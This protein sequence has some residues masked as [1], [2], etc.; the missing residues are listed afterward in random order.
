[1]TQHQE[2]DSRPD[3]V[4]VHDK[5][6]VP[7][8]TSCYVGDQYTPPGSIDSTNLNHLTPPTVSVPTEA[9]ATDT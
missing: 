7:L 1:M 6:E 3:Y 5:R 8:N 4:K 2:T 9:P